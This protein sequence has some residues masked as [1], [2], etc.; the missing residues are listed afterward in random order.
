MPV[1]KPAK[2]GKEEVSWWH[3]KGKWSLRT[4]LLLA[5]FKF[6]LLY[7]HRL[8]TLN[9]MKASEE[10]SEEQSRQVRGNLS[11]NLVL[12]LKSS[13][14]LTSIMRMPSFSAA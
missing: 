8:I 14:F 4:L 3:G 5:S 7:S 9:G 1:S 2:I 12:I 10:I 13:F 11:I 6:I